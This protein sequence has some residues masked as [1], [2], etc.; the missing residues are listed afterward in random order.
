MNLI[1]RYQNPSGTLPKRKFWETDEEYQS[2]VSRGP[3][4]RSRDRAEAYRI[5]RE[6]R[7]NADGTR[8]KIDADINAREERIRNRHNSSWASRASALNEGV[9]SSMKDTVQGLQ[10]GLNQKQGQDIM[11]TI[12][13]VKQHQEENP[14]V[15]AVPLAGE[16]LEYLQ[17]HNDEGFRFMNSAMAADALYGLSPAIKNILSKGGHYLS[18]HGLGGEK[19]LFN[20]SWDRL[21]ARKYSPADFDFAKQIGSGGESIV[22]EDPRNPDYVIKVTK[23]IAEALGDFKGGY[24]YAWDVLNKHPLFQPYRYAG[25]LE[26]TIYGKNF[27]QSIENGSVYRQKKLIPGEDSSNLRKDYMQSAL[28]AG[29]PEEYGYFTDEYFAR[30]APDNTNTLPSNKIRLGEDIRESNIGYTDDGKAKLFDYVPTEKYPGIVGS[31]VTLSNANTIR[32]ALTHGEPYVIRN[33]VA[34]IEKYP[35]LPIRVGF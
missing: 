29:L 35:L 18:T 11:R 28:D 15:N 24:S 19:S 16:D 20:R 1:P 32:Y 8:A 31:L 23:P 13:E 4:T 22:F 34:R 12:E 27:G 33:G 7:M 3:D 10:N 30:N 14:M 6:N 26:G 2:R 17:N 5:S 9:A 21:T 25:E